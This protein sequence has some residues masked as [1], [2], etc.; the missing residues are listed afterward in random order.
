MSNPWSRPHERIRVL[1]D[2]LNTLRRVLS[3]VIDLLQVV[4]MAD[5]LLL[6]VFQSMI[7]QIGR[8]ANALVHICRLT[9]VMTKIVPVMFFIFVYVTV[10]GL[11]C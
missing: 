6:I 4:D 11:F 1:H 8:I 3:L 2:V 9:H 7:V 10:F 5:W